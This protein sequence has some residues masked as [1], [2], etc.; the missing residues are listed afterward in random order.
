MGGSVPTPT[1]EVQHVADVTS[2]AVQHTVD[3]VA[4]VVP[5]GYAI[6]DMTGQVNMTLHNGLQIVV[7]QE[8]YISDA[9]GHAWK[10]IESDPRLMVLII[11]VAAIV[12]SGAALEFIDMVEQAIAEGFEDMF[13]E[14]AA[15]DSIGDALSNDLGDEL[16]SQGMSDAEIDAQLEEFSSNSRIIGQEI[17]GDS[18]SMSPSFQNALGKISMRT[19]MNGGDVKKAVVGYLTG[20]AGSEAGDVVGSGLDSQAIGNIC[21]AGTTAALNKGDIRTAMTQSLLSQ[22]ISPAAEAGHGLLNPVSDPSSF[23]TVPEVTSLTKRSAIMDDTTTDNSAGSDA[24]ISDASDPSAPLNS[25]TDASGNQQ[26]ISPDGSITTYNADGSAS[27]IMPDGTMY[28]IA[29]DGTVTQTSTDGSVV[30]I[31]GSAGIPSAAGTGGDIS[32]FVASL[33][34][35]ANQALQLKQAWLKV[36]SPPARQ[37]VPVR[38]ANGALVTYN[39]NGTMTTRQPNGSVATTL[40]PVG[41]PYTFPDGVTV[42]NNGDGTYSTINPDG[43]T[44]TA[45][46]PAVSGAGGAALAVGVGLGLLA[47]MR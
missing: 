45:K 7:D 32:G 4:P 23:E 29:A 37:A 41:H 33:T 8:K 47:F 16:V 28:T 40:I 43:T 15:A 30:D 26:E 12:T 38:L 10:V 35:Y 18:S 6:S 24:V 27:Q 3:V 17:A 1:E 21:A 44:S 34:N 39:R 11:I 20:V 31:T 13:A 46:L 5:F 19:A 14:D 9:A 42:M 36:G 25:G 22:S 2:S